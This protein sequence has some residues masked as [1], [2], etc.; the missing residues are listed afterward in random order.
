MRTAPSQAAG[1]SVGEADA[2]ATRFA[3]GANWERFARSLSSP[4][5]DAARQ[6]LATMLGDAAIEGKTFLDI[7]AGSGL[8]SLAAV[9]LGAR[10]VHSVDYDQDS[11][12]TAQD[13]KARFSPD[14]PWTI[15]HGSALDVEF[16]RGLGTFDIVYSW[17]VLHH[18]GD[19]WRGL[20]LTIGRVAR[21]GSLFISIYNDQERA[22][23]Y[24]RRIKR[25]YNRMPAPLR[26]PYAVAVMLPAELR[27]FA[28]LL[29]KLKPGSYVRLWRADGQRTRGMSRWHDLIDW[30]GGYPF[31]VA[32]PEEVFTFCT[33]RGL[34]M[35]RMSTC[36]GGPGC[37]QF[38]FVR[39]G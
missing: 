4:Q 39:E 12:R 6:S 36:G 19:M 38:V 3:F 10:A 25:L 31:E 28:S 37:N 1:P 32:T 8:F 7:G 29:I 9:S 30:V 20:D 26:M 18:T 17:G 21:G 33:T 13:M 15:E 2:D 5:A 27:T 34:R 23:R 11:V 16:M 24:W 35:T 14:A 22:S